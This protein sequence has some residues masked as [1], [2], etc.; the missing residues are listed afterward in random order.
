MRGCRDLEAR[1][2]RA[3]DTSVSSPSAAV[4]APEIEK[5]ESGLSG[6]D[7]AEVEA[8]AKEKKPG[9]H[10]VENTLDRLGLITVRNGQII[11]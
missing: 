9:Y 5:M 4:P 2:L 3:Q 1:D 11:S 7:P 10:C 8:E 6:T